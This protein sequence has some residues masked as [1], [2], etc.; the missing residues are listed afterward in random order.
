M[1]E[2]NPYLFRTKE[3]KGTDLSN[4][5]NVSLCFLYRVVGSFVFLCVKGPD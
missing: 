2:S 1:N 4:K 3:H 5:E